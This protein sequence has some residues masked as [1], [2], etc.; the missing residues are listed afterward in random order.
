MNIVIIGAGQLGSRHL[1]GLAL[2]EYDL[3]I[4]LV[5]PNKLS[6]DISK[7]RF[8]DINKSNNKK[9]FLVNSL[10]DIPKTIDFAIIS[11][12]SIHRLDALRMLLDNSIVKYLLLEKFLFPTIEEYHIAKQILRK[13]HTITYVN[14]SRRQIDSYKVLKQKLNS[15]SRINLSITGEMWNIGSNAIHFFDLF[16]FLSDGEH[17]EIDF[18]NSSLDMINSKHRGYI[19]FLGKLEGYSDNGNKIH[20]ECSDGEKVNFIIKIETEQGVYLIDEIN[21]RIQINGV[22]DDFLIPPQSQR[23]NKLLEQLLEEG[24]CDLP[25]FEQSIEAHIVLLKVFKYFLKEQEGI[26]T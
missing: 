13:T 16:Y 18:G 9:L 3:N 5:D 10:K 19:E 17:L 22:N 14:C 7:Q 4:F 20:L 1:Q 11:T 12:T 21:E 2:V 23:T 24:K 6:L 8:E 25:S 26:V 15:S